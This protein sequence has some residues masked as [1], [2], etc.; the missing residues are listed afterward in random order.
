MDKGWRRLLAVMMALT[1]VAAGCGGDDGESSGGGSGD[2]GGGDTITVPEDCATIQAAVD[3]AE[4]GTLILVSPGTYEEAVDVTTDDLVIR[5]LDRNEVILEGNFELENGVRM[6]EADGVA[7]ENLTVQNYTGNGVFW[8]G[9]DGYRASYLTAIRNGGYGV[10]AFGSVN[11]LLE[12]SYASGSADS[13]F[14][15]GQCYPCNAVIRDVVSEYN[16]LGYSGTNSGGDLFIVESE[17]RDNRAG[18]TMNSASTEGCAPHRE[19]TVV[20]NYFHDNSNEQTDAKDVP[21]LAFGNGVLALGSIG[22]VIQR[23]RVENH[24]IAGIAVVPGP[25]IDPVSPVIEDPAGF[26]GTE[27]DPCV[28][29]TVA[30]SEEVIAGLENPQLWEASDNQ[31]LDN[32][33]IG[34]DEWDLVL[35]TLSGAGDGNCFAGNEATITAPPSIETVLPC[36][37]A[38]QSYAPELA[39][40]LEILD[41]ERP[42]VVPYEDVDLPDPGELENM[43]D[44]A[45]APA[46]PAGPPPAIDLAA[47]PVPAAG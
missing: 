35:L 31:V 33:V 4:P 8:T 24:L 3:S 32:V 19:T 36:E 15:I 2:C 20:G 42:P 41:A 44:A 5:G 25:D 28:E 11:G 47:I 40:F 14:Y 46:E 29:N 22:N 34:S 10:Y 23:N 43:P 18:M 26:P 30:A 7:V 6:V 38:Q 9:S 17:F 45:D 39:R 13:G 37:G 12:H 1:A 27:A 16:G 21:N